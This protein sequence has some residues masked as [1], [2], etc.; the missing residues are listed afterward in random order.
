MHQIL[1]H[2][3]SFSMPAI[4]NRFVDGLKQD[5]TAVVF[6]QRPLDLDTYCCLSCSVTGGSTLS[7]LPTSINWL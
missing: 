4:V 1:A 2:D 6:V 5:I 3:P 7:T